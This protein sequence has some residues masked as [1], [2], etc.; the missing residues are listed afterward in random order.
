MK[1]NV[2]RFLALVIAALG[3]VALLVVPVAA[4]CQYAHRELND[5]EQF[6]KYTESGASIYWL[7]SNSSVSTGKMEVMVQ[8][9]DGRYVV[10]KQYVDVGSHLSGSRISAPSAK[11]RVSLLNYWSKT[12]GDG[13]VCCPY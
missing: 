1:K 3:A 13:T 5:P 8:R 2:K 4:D 7:G 12:K 10:E 9:D 6:S 11:H